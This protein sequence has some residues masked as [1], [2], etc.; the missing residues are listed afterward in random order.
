MSKN[1]LNLTLPPGSLEP[2]GN[3]P[4]APPSAAAESERSG[5]FIGA[6]SIEALQEKLEELGMDESQRKR[7]EFFLCQKEKITG[8]ELSDSDFEKL[9][10]LGAG[11]GGVVMKVKHCASG[12]IMARKD[13]NPVT[14]RASYKISKFDETMYAKL[15]RTLS[16]IQ[17]I[18]TETYTNN[19]YL[20]QLDK[21][22]IEDFLCT[23]R[24]QFS[25]I[26]PSSPISLYESHALSPELHEAVFHLKSAI[27]VLFGF[28]RRYITDE[29]FLDQTRQWLESLIQILLRVA[30]W[31]DHMF[32]LSHVLRCPSGIHSWAVQYIQ[33]PSIPHNTIQ[34][35]VHMNHVLTLLSVITSPVQ[36]REQ[37]LNATT[38]VDS[39]EHWVIINED[40]DDDEDDVDLASY[41][42][43]KE[44]DVIA[45]LNQIPVDVLVRQ[46][47]CIR[48]DMNILLD[49]ITTESLLRL[50]AISTHTIDILYRAIQTY[51]K[52]KQLTKR[53][54]R[55]YIHIVEYLTDYMSLL[56]EHTARNKQLDL[57]QVNIEYNN[58][59]LQCVTKL[60]ELNSN[61]WFFL[62]QIPFKLT[63]I[64]MCWRILNYLL[65]N[66]D[67][68]DKSHS[69]NL[70]DTTIE[71]L[72]KL[73]D[74]LS[75]YL[76]N[77]ISNLITCRDTSEIDLVYTIVQYMLHVGYLESKLYAKYNKLCENLLVNIITQ[78]NHLISF[79]LN[80]V[81]NQQSHVHN[82]NGKLL[83]YLFNHVNIAS[84]VPSMS[85]ID[86]LTTWLLNLSITHKLNNLA[87]FIISKFDYTVL[88][89]ELQVAI[90]VGIAR[91]WLQ[92]TPD[93]S[94]NVS[95]TL[96]TDSMS[97]LIKPVNN[98]QIFNQWCWQI[99]FK[100]RLHL[101]DLTNPQM[102][103]DHL[104]NLP[105]Y[106]LSLPDLDSTQDD[107]MQLLSSCIHGN[108][109]LPCYLV[110]LITNLGHSLPLIN[111]RAWSILN[112]LLNYYRYSSVINILQHILPLFIHSR[113][114]L[115]NNY[116]FLN[117][118]ISLLNA[119]RTYLK[120]A[121][122]LI[123]SNF[124]GP[125]LKNL[126]HM[127]HFQLNNFH[128]YGLS[129]CHELLLLWIEIICAVYKQ[130]ELS[131]TYLLDNILQYCIYDEPLKCQVKDIFVKLIH[132]LPS[133]NTNTGI[134]SLVSWVSSSSHILM[135]HTLLTKPLSHYANYEFFTLVN[136][137]IEEYLLQIK[138]NLW[139][140]LLVELN[141]NTGKTNID[142]SLK[143]VC[144]GLKLSPL[145]SSH[146]SLYR[147]LYYIVELPL[148][149]S[150]LSA[151]FVQKFFSLYLQRMN[152]VC[153]GHKFF[154]GITNNSLSKRLKAKLKEFQNY[155]ETKVT[156]LTNQ[157]SDS[158][159]NISHE[160]RIG[161]FTSVTN[162]F[163]SYVLWLDEPRLLE[164]CLYLPALPPAYD[165]N[166]LA[167]LVQNTTST[168]VQV[169]WYEYANYVGIKADH[170]SMLTELSATQNR[171]YMKKPKAGVMGASKEVVGHR[172]RIVK[173]LSSYETSKKL[174]K[175]PTHENKLS[176]A[177]NKEI[178][179]NK[180]IMLATLKSN[181]NHIVEYSDV[182]RMQLLETKSLNEQYKSLLRTLYMDVKNE[183]V[184][185]AAC[186]V[187]TTSASQNERYLNCA[188]P[189]VI[190]IR[191]NESKLNTSVEHILKQ[192]RM[193]CECLLKGLM[194]APPNTISLS[195][196]YI[197][198]FI[199]VLIKEYNEVKLIGDYKLIHTIK[200]TSICLFYEFLDIYIHHDYIYLPIV[201]IFN[202][203]VDSLAQVFIRDTEDEC[204]HLLKL[205]LH[206]SSKLYEML[207]KHFHP[208]HSSTRK[209][210]EM[211][212][213]LVCINNLNEEKIPGIVLYN[214]LNKFN[215]NLW[216]NNKK[217]KLSERTQII[218]LII[219]ALS[220]IQTQDNDTGTRQVDDKYG[221]HLTYRKH[222]VYM[223]TYE[224]PEHYGE[225]LNALL[226]FSE[227][228]SLHCDVWYDF[229]NVL[230]YGE[231]AVDNIVQGGDGPK[232][233]VRSG[234]AVSM[235]RE[236]TRRYAVEQHALSL[237]EL[238]GTA[239]LLGS[240]FTKERLQYGLYGL[241]P[242]YKTYGE[243]IGILLGLLSHALIVQTLYQCKGLVADKLSEQLWPT[244]VSVYSPWI[245][246]Y[247]TSQLTE[248][249][250]SWIQQ[251]TDDRS[252][253]QPW[254]EADIQDASRMVL[255]FVETM[256]FMLEMLPASTNIYSFIW[257]FYTAHF[258]HS[259][260]KEHVLGVIHSHLIHLQ[261]IKFL[262]NLYDLELMLKLVDQYLPACHTF[263]SQ[264][265]IQIQWNNVIQK[266]HQ[267][268]ATSTKIH[269]TLL[270]LLIK[271][272]NEPSI[273]QSNK[274]T[275]L[276]LEAQGYSWHLV[277]AQWYE[278]VSNW[279]V[280]SYE[281]H[282]ML[283]SN[284][285]TP[286][287][288]LDVAALDLL[289]V[290]AGYVK[291]V[292]TYHP[293]TS[294]KRQIF[295]RACVRMTL[296]L[297]TR[298]KNIVQSQ[299]ADVKQ[300]IC[301]M[302]DKVETIIESSVPDHLQVYESGLLLSELLC[303]L[304]QSNSLLGSLSLEAFSD[305]LSLRTNRSVVL[306]G[307]LKVSGAVV[308]NDEALGT[309]LEIC[310]RA[311]FCNTSPR[312]VD[313]QGEAQPPP[314]PEWSKLVTIF[315]KVP[316]KSPPFESALVSHNHLLTLYT[317]LVKNIPP[318]SSDLSQNA[319]VLSKLISYINSIVP[320]EGLD[321][322]KLPLLWCLFVQL[323]I[324]GCEQSNATVQSLTVLL[325]HL[326]EFY[327]YK[328]A[329]Q[330]LHA[331]GIKKHTV[332][333]NR[334]RV[335]SKALVSYILVQLPERIEG[336]TTPSMTSQ[337]VRQT[338]L[339]P[340]HLSSTSS[341]LVPS[342]EALRSVSQLE[343]LLSDKNYTDLKSQIELAL[344]YIRSADN[345]LHNCDQFIMRLAK[346]L[347]SEA[348]IQAVPL[349]SDDVPSV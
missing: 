14:A 272:S 117:I 328:Q 323:C 34:S 329:W 170:M 237:Y 128:L 243:V 62:P 189:A 168:S 77:T 326:N 115:V 45:L 263:L 146:L 188:G 96:L 143:K 300:S 198:N 172:E 6:T 181:F 74:E 338:A 32:I 343:Q 311:W 102:I 225:I 8:K 227:N 211:Y 193:E 28:Q 276:L 195:T 316:P 349:D 194:I 17:N 327:N 233:Y 182:Y 118:V 219:N 149:S 97:Y 187:D 2:I 241:Y 52:H 320:N 222:L 127:I 10:E 156:E 289:Q 53:L 321:E 203:Y 39:K 108:Q 47:L 7:M 220:N 40:T 36:S 264:V 71:Y 214:L 340:G 138:T 151:L 296:Q 267:S 223:L 167:G 106:L 251:L 135:N 3:T 150:K 303:L 235:L 49:E 285:G 164:P 232:Q 120:L 121:K 83:L 186:D 229:I 123:F 46:L 191:V 119:D 148:S 20:C 137:E 55:L 205:M 318:G 216:L 132:T 177:I 280:M 23:I 239:S 110:L 56:L 152:N 309:L 69:Y 58:I 13:G 154:E 240:H 155:Y 142:A 305:W 192:N 274:I 292:A 226:K 101:F 347:Y 236:L 124:P 281:P 339:A 184:L 245:L 54:V 44:N 322:S 122:N 66:V 325:N 196:I 157:D 82:D 147:Y 283:Q 244:L 261:W 213:L 271:L 254:V 246:P 334:C 277:D 293:T 330:L 107:S 15:C 212:D 317:L 99:V 31:R 25:A 5:K 312:S 342:A 346:Q 262:P 288:S 204:Y 206:H 238:Q 314:P 173:R 265:F 250:A 345:S 284:I 290:A 282:V 248:P 133:K 141:N 24:E 95:I 273:R 256:K 199:N 178:I 294:R 75:I 333:S 230:L 139:P 270:H 38:Q 257:Q 144:S 136:L 57:R 65:R 315:Q 200:Q 42:L 84:Y 129:S 190:R 67:A 88:Y 162:L 179:L 259:S 166:R 231:A 202:Q 247:L 100:L 105:A 112:I 21:L 130:D 207:H 306:R 221:I 228:E 61:S 249:T 1:K 324:T 19:V 224:F 304:N 258:T 310:V 109:S 50:L 176:T 298:Y 111:E 70:T 344:T 126:A 91:A 104:T 73:D 125:V 134:S 307:V 60:T 252:I 279:F 197:H 286:I 313:D 145:T 89:H 64:H 94:T 37:F 131:C 253:L 113:Q 299:Q 295:V 175:L 255:G 11:N 331:I 174:T 161:Y 242:K 269:C 234:L 63:S 218:N 158:D 278:Q 266:Y 93:V 140:Q 68:D 160:D 86:I 26:P 27:S 348:Y 16:C 78:R 81:H 165:P 185:N 163:R 33:A 43:L 116:M 297:A 287:T 341:D 59:I 319:A 308:K 260:M 335:L 332:V 103:R 80:E 291:N 301:N 302:I 268:D 208:L 48:Y 90:A 183:V 30:T 51:V 76:L 29:E 18:V 210:I 35:L 171:L 153:V 92:H 337:Y 4:S 275:P 201:H 12:L 85:D 87:R 72:A 159:G 217:P 79:I 41:A 9:G 209:Y 98:E 336:D 215:L 114:L 180:E 22:K 169:Y